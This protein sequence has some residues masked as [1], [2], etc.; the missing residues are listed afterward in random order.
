MTELLHKDLTQQII[1]VYYRVYN[2]LGQT[3]PEFI[4]EKAMLILLKRQGIRCIRQDKYKI[5][6]KQ[7]IVGLQQLDLFVADQ[8]VVELKVASSVEPIHL[9]QLLSY[10][11]VVSKEVG[12]FFRFGGPEP[13]F[14]RRVLTVPAWSETLG[15][16]SAV[17][18]ERDGWLYPKIT[19]EIIG[20]VLEV[21]KTLGPGFIHR[22]YANACYHELK[23]RGLEIKP[24]R[25]FRVFLDDIDLGEIKLGHLQVEN[26]ALVFPVAV[27]NMERIKITNL[28]AWMRYL[29]IP[30]GI[31]VNFNTTRL[32]PVIL[33]I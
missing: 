17:L 1:G 19:Q 29:D 14:V 11:K 20:G 12:L 7:K 18:T 9:A 26:C 23:L 31:L 28:K 15:P 13:E 32:E 33:C 5:T 16:V 6:Y 3:Y 24:H 27:S 21:Y 30:I 10:L 22:I 4:Y 8:V 2:N 25:E